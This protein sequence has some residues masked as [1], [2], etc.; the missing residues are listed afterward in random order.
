MKKQSLFIVLLFSVITAI[1]FYPVFRGK[2]PF[3][4]DSL[5]SLTPFNAY[6]Y[7]GFAPGGVPNK[8]LGEDPVRILYPWKNFTV[9]QLKKG[10]LPFW[11]PYNFS[12]NPHF[13]NLQSGTFSP[14]TLLFLLLPFN[15]AWTLTLLTEVFLTGIFTYLFLKQNKLSNEASLFGGIVFSYS[16]AVVLWLQY[17]NFQGTFLWLPLA[18]LITKAYAEKPDGKKL[19]YLTVILFIVLLSGYIQLAIYLFLTVFLYGIFLFFTE[20]KK[21]AVSRKYLLLLIPFFLSVFLAAFQ[22][23]P[24]LEIFT[25]SARNAYTFTDLSQRLIPV[26]N[27]VTVVIPDFFG[28]P[29]TRNYWLNGT[30]IERAGYIGIIPFLFV[31]F[32]WLGKK[33]PSALFFFFLG[34]ISYLSALDILP[35]K[36]FHSLGI[37]VLSTTVPSRILALYCFAFSVTAA[38]GIDA[39]EK[40]QDRKQVIKILIPFG[41]L[42]I[43]IWLFVLMQKDPNF[44]VTKRNLFIPTGLFVVG[45]ILLVQKFLPKKITVLL[46]LLI[47]VFDLFYFFHKVT[48][49]SP[50]AFVYPK[51]EVFGKLSEMQ[52]IDRFWG[53]G[54]A[55]VTSE[56]NLPYHLYFPEGYDPLFIKRYGEL[57]STTKDGKIPDKIP[58]TDVN[59]LAGYGTADL[60]NN[61]YRQRI[62]NLLGVKY[63]LHKVSPSEAANPD[64]ATFPENIYALKYHQG[65]FQIYENKQAIPRVFLAG[66]YIVKNNKEDILHTIF[67]K[68]L[69][70]RKTLILEEKLPKDISPAESTHTNVKLISYE[71]NKIVL[72]TTAD[73]NQL[74]FLSD[75]FYPGWKA[76]VDGKSET[77]YRAD[78]SFRAVPVQKGT[79]TVI[80]SYYPP[81]FDFGMKIAFISGI[82]LIA[83]YFLPR[84]KI[85]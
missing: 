79:H 65:P 62:M 63:V 40:Q 13:S 12:G 17:G 30:Y 50:Q 31:F 11:N 77:I 70:L 16:A 7:L 48:P 35:V 19:V 61:Y 78:Y 83:L 44:L 15:S 25:N 76:T 37:P 24:L 58:R 54:S 33:N 43:A 36:L 74:L 73:N 28:N 82:G 10:Q 21:Q 38:F 27:L 32:I 29:A 5:V 85:V 75:N 8:G 39:W 22:L 34:V 9:E 4:G 55:S 68:Q 52:G 67:D 81:S 59:I 51:A 1:F 69:D 53:Y 41:L 72:A 2:M 49:F 84:R 23:I 26:V 56:I 80:F 6:S 71:P 46:F 3:P 64:T 14:F 45:A 42:F 60:R 47:T 66:S 57:A 20:K 18:L